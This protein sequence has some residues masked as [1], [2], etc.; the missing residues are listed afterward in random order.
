VG[1]T[2]PYRADVRETPMEGCRVGRKTLACI[3]VIV[4]VSVQL[5]VGVLPWAAPAA[6]QTCPGD[7]NGDGEVT[8]DEIVTAVNAALEGCPTPPKPTPTPTRSSG[9]TATPTRPPV[10]GCTATFDQATLG[11]LFQ[12][13]INSTC[14]GDGSTVNFTVLP[15]VGVSF[16]LVP[17]GALCFSIPSG[18]FFFLAT[19]ASATTA[20]LTNWS[21][22]LSDPY[23]QHTLSGT[24]TLSP[25]GQHLNLHPDTSPFSV[26]GCPFVEFVGTYHPT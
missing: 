17:P 22:N 15:G 5:A 11:C 7:L 13:R 18:C 26:N 19:P 16:S 1:Q 21:N 4:I 2:R 8:V 10:T 24:V 25:D 23:Y 14:G 20:Q 12:G 9:P 3:I 6:A